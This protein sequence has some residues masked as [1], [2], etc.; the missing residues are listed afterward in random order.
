[1]RSTSQA[2]GVVF[3]NLMI[4]RGGAMANDCARRRGER[5]YPSFILLGGCR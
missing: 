1:M 5:N 4:L 2:V 3:C